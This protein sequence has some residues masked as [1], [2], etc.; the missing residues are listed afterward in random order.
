[1]T[2]ATFHTWDGTRLAF[3]DSGAPAGGET[4]PT[5]LLTNGLTCTASYWHFVKADLERDHRVLTWDLRGHGDSDPPM[6][7]SHVRMDDMAR[8][9]LALMD[10]VG[11]ERAVLGGFSMGVEVVLEAC[12]LAPQRCHAILAI[13]GTFKNPVGGL[14]NNPIPPAAWRLGLESVV[15]V[16]PGLASLAWHG[17]FRLPFRH[18]VVRALGACGATE[19]LMAPYYAHQTRLHVPTVLAMGAAGTRH[20][21]GPWLHQVPCPVLVVGGTDDRFTPLALSHTLRDRIPDVDYLEIEGITH[22][23]L[24]EAPA[25][26][27]QAIRRFLGRL[28]SDTGS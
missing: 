24:L 25:P 12:R 5:V 21:A 28:S 1:M 27:I 10:H 16:A 6:D 20:D 22:T 4:G 26:I 19:P 3:T 17:A 14:F 2:S 13:T 7:P 15:R 11:L 18:G 8:D 23:G 9:L